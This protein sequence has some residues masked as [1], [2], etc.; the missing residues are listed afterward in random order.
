MC[1]A[2]DE[3]GTEEATFDDFWFP[4]DYSIVSREGSGISSD[5][6]K[7]YNIS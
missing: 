6:G 4:D 5:E 7:N 2:T 3:D 1:R